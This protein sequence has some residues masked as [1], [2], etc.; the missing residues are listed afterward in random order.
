MALLYGRAGRL[1]TENA[2]FWPGQI[3]LQRAV[4]RMLHLNTGS[5]FLSWHTWLVD[6]LRQ[7]VVLTK[8][9]NR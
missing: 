4:R 3:A 9:V 5:A 8:V 1:N 2:G 6:Q 7:K